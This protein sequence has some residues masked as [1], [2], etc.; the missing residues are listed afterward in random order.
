MWGVSS[1]VT[2]YLTL[3][4]SVRASKCASVVHDC[5]WKT[6]RWTHSERMTPFSCWL[7]NCG[8]RNGWEETEITLGQEAMQQNAAKNQCTSTHCRV[9]AHRL[10]F[11]RVPRL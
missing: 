1:N 5:T 8:V 9:L 7:L 4:D 11:L 6:S 2:R 10:L 3:R